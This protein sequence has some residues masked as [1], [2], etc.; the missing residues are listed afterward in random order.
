MYLDIVI[1]C[2]PQRWRSELPH[3]LRPEEKA[4]DTKLE[5]TPSVPK[6][7][8]VLGK[9]NGVPESSGP[10]I[11]SNPQKPSSVPKP[12]MH[13]PG[14]PPPPGWSGSSGGTPV[15]VNLSQERKKKKKKEQSGVLG[16]IS[17]KPMRSSGG[18]SDAR[19]DE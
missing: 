6:Q 4:H 19:L 13:R 1:S 7:D 8:P 11:T 15:I 18:K 2:F 9:G 17:G 16:W 14:P 12:Q 10:P 5:E 3:E